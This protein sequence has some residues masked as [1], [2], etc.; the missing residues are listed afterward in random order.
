M[1]ILKD[2]DHIDIRHLTDALDKINT[3]EFNKRKHFKA[4]KNLMMNDSIASS[5]DNDYNNDIIKPLTAAK[6]PP[7]S[8]ITQ[9]ILYP[10][11]AEYL[12]IQKGIH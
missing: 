11:P 5:T 9:S 2:N 12:R 3:A 8:V 4:F 1:T 7:P 10:R 6:K